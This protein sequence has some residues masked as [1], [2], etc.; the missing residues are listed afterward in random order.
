MQTTLEPSQFDGI[1]LD[2]D[3]SR[4]HPIKSCTLIM[5]NNELVHE[6]WKHKREA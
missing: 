5:I 4:I 3:F 1:G 2:D 6:E